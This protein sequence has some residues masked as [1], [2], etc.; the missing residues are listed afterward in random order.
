MII[1]MRNGRSSEHACYKLILYSNLML[2]FLLFRQAILV[3]SNLMLEFSP[4]NHR[5]FPDLRTCIS[6]LNIFSNRCNSSAGII[7][8]THLSRTPLGK[9]LVR[10]GLHSSFLR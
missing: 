3:Y 1:C 7:G 2:E 10:Q 4:F 8:G 5:S 6:F 9:W